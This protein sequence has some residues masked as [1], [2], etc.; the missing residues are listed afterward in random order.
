METATVKKHEIHFDQYM[1]EIY[2]KK[3]E[4][5][6]VL[7]KAIQHRMQAGKEGLVLH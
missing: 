2:L 1:F 3:W 5:R 7:K 4:Q 6:T